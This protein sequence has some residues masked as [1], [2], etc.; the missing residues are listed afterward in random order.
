MNKNRFLVEQSVR[1]IR[2]VS[3]ASNEYYHERSE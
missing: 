3:F 1:N 2:V